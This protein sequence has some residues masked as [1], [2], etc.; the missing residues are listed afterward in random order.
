MNNPLKGIPRQLFKLF[1]RITAEYPQHG[2]VDMNQLLIA[3][4]MVNKKAAG[5]P[6]RN[7]LNNGQCLFI[8]SN[9]KSSFVPHIISLPLLPDSIIQFYGTKEKSLEIF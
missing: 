8:K 3:V 2:A 7:L 5:Q 6:L 1:Q 4:R 9:C